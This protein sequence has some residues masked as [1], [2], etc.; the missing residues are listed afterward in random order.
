M[1]V[2]LG[3]VLVMVREGNSRVV[4]NAAMDR[5]YEL[6]EGITQPFEGVRVG[7]RQLSSEFTD[8]SE[9]EASNLRR[10]KGG[11]KKASQ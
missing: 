1:E 9:S 2:E 11:G 8:A 7:H 5:L 6:L 10:Q 3:D 4:V